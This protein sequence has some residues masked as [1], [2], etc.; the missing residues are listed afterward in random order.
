M[1][2]LGCQA[3]LPPKFLALDNTGNCMNPY[4][5]K[6][7][8]CSRSL[9]GGWQIGFLCLTGGDYMSIHCVKKAPEATIDS[10]KD[11]A[12]TQISINSKMD[13]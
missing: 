4:L 2:N 13:R 1:E 5:L 11:N 3:Q 6:Y 7:S 10:G 12:V 8:E 9:P